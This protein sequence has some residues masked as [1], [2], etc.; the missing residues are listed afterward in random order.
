[1]AEGASTAAD[2]AD[3]TL[4]TPAAD[5]HSGHIFG[6]ELLDV[7]DDLHCKLY[8]E[9]VEPA[10]NNLPTS[11][12][13][14]RSRCNYVSRLESRRYQFRGCVGRLRVVCLWGEREREERA[15][16]TSNSQERV[17][18]EVGESQMDEP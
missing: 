1:M 7:L 6:K 16:S 8:A 11:F 4:P 5:V 10:Y 13:F 18:R 17:G 12:I 9:L 2:N 14:F 3:C 15:D